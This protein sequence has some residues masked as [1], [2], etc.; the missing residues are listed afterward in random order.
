MTRPQPRS[1]KWH[2]VNRMSFTPWAISETKKRI[3]SSSRCWVF[4]HARNGGKSRPLPMRARKRISKPG[5]NDD[6]KRKSAL[7]KMPKSP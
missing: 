1:R 2:L 6:W 4:S 3:E 7:K 5:K